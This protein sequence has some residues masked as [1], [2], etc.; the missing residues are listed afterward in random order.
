MQK[1]I[2]A[3]TN[4][5][6]IEATRLGFTKMFPDDEFEFEGISVPSGVSDQPMTEEETLR[7]A[8]NRAENAKKEKP[9]SDYWVG[10]EGGLEEING[11]M[12]TF[13]WMYM[14]SK[15]GQIGKGRTGSF[16][17]PEKVAKLVREGE[18]LGIADD[19]VFGRTN[20]KQSNGSVGI[21]T[22][23]VI[24]RTSYYEPALVFTLIPFKNPDLY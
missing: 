22:H 17:L 4:P 24:T 14:I 21:L 15:S 13:A 16:F 6:K 2:V 1:V 3:S 7:G 5:V 9:D 20:S 19:K 8:K 18:E 10:I 11:E 12:E 23:D